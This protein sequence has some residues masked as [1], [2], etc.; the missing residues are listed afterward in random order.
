M[1][2]IIYFLYQA[3]EITKNVYNKTMNSIKLQNKEDTIFMNSE[4]SKIFV[5]YRLLLDLSTKADLKRSDKCVALSNLG[6]YYIR[7]NKKSLTKTINL[8]YQL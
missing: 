8:K 2:E 5:P 4:K 1:R 6:I 3:M 7:K